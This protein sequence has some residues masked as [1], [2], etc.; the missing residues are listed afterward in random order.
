MFD[1]AGPA[2]D[3]EPSSIAERDVWS[4]WVGESTGLHACEA[5]NLEDFRGFRSGYCEDTETVKG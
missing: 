3:A 1:K 5:T 4:S 2:A